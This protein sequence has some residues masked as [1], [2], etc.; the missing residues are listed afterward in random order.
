VSGPIYVS[1]RV[2]G[3]TKAEIDRFM[4]DHE[5]TEQDAIRRLLQLGITASKRLPP[6]GL[7]PL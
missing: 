6:K 1:T 3:E 4:K 7:Q 5:C 2:S